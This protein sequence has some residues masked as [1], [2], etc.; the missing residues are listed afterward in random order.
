MGLTSYV[1]FA[2]GRRDN[3][4][5]QCGKVNIP[6][7]P[8]AHKLTGGSSVYAPATMSVSAFE[9]FDGAVTHDSTLWEIRSAD[10]SFTYPVFKSET[11]E[12]L[13]ELAVPF[14]LLEFGRSY[15]WRATYIDSKGRKSLPNMEAGF[16]YG[17][18]AKSENLIFLKDTEWKYNADGNN[19]GTTWRKAEYDDSAWP[20]GK[21]YLGRATSRQKHK[22]TTTLKMGATTFYFRKA[23]VF[24]QPVGGGELQIN[25]LIDDGAVFYLNG[26]QIHRANMKE[27]GSIRYTTRASSTVTDAD[28]SGQIVL[29]GKYLKQ[30]ENILAVEVHQYST[31]DR[32]LAFGL[33]LRA[34]VESLPDG[35]ILN[36]LMAANRGS[37]THTDTSPDW[38]ELHNP[39]NRDVDLGGAGLG[40]GVA[41]EP[42]FFFPADTILPAKGHLVVW[43]DDQKESPGLHTGFALD[44]DGQNIALWWPSDEGLKIQDA[45]GFGPQADDLSLGREPDGL[46]SWTLNTP[47]PGLANL[48]ADLGSISSLVINEWMARPEDGDDWL[49]L[50][51]NSSLPIPLA[52]LRLSDD[53][54]QPDKTVMPPLTFIGPNG[55]LRL[56]ADNS[57]ADGPTHLGFRLSG[58]GEEIVLIDTKDKVID[59]VLFGEQPRGTSEGCYPDGA[60]SIVFFPNSATPGR[61]NLILGDS[62]EDGLPNLWEDRYGL[63]PNDASDAVI[64]TDNDGHTNL[65]ELLAGTKPNDD[66]SVLWLDLM[67]HQHNMNIT[68]DAQ[69]GRTY[70]LWNATNI[71]NGKW[72]KVEEFPPQ[73]SKRTIIHN[74]PAK[75]R[76]APNG[77][78]RITIPAAKN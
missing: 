29:S 40:D 34:T 65:E 3:V 60:K 30:G 63:N 46:G 68:F 54:V 20:S 39:T 4:N 75:H 74:L 17:G 10:G 26:K 33:S 61:S 58:S 73:D 12:N 21:S 24:D 7:R 27:R 2:Q 50:F 5:K 59:S 32:D 53:P 14:D 78:Y 23:F 35:V 25:Y 16:R 66:D 47:T 44:A 42:S 18:H 77:Y 76:S 70:V 22:M 19:L 8:T 37:V 51:N 11:T 55:F 56:T 69:A 41:L 72:I 52:G 15:Y 62:D 57:P 48:G 6:A 1:N 9:S 13:T 43:C 49:E 28:L 71:T 31:N 64:D 45:I 67:M 38:I 36:E